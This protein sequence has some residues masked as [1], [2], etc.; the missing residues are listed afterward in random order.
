M[1]FG[2]DCP[3]NVP[4]HSQPFFISYFHKLP[5]IAVCGH[6]CRCSDKFEVVSGV[7]FKLLET[8]NIHSCTEPFYGIS[9]RQ[10]PDFLCESVKGVFVLS[11]LLY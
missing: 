5:E 11:H 7:V 2:K 1:S 4:N 6:L 8:K 9:H 10:S 3:S